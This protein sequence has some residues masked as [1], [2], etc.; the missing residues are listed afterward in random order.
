MLPTAIAAYV[1]L[2]S[3]RYILQSFA[4]LEMVAIYTFAYKVASG[5]E[6]LI[7]RPYALD[8]APRRFA[9]AAHPDPGLRFAEAL[10]I[11]LILTCTGGLVIA[12]VAPF[13]FTLLVPPTYHDGLSILP[14]ILMAIIIFGAS[15]PLNIGIMLR[16][17]TYLLPW[18]S[19]FAALVCLVLN[20][21]WIPNYS[22]VGAA[23]A[24]LVA[25]TIYTAA[26]GIV[27]ARIY[28]VCYNFRRLGLVV[29]ATLIGLLGIIIVQWFGIAATLIGLLVGLGWVGL[30]MSVTALCLW[31][32]STRIRLGMGTIG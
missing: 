9:I 1:L 31:H 7:I 28:H 15:Y 11:Y 27:S 6:A 23:W 4:S 8:W 19:W 3:D 30:I 18:L 10:V 14:I 25:Y 13:V 21:W 5:L 20:F 32:R 29:V 16:D 24:T 2:A 26:I 17:R 12:A 22:I